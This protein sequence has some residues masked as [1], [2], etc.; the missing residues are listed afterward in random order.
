MESLAIMHYCSSY[1]IAIL[2]LVLAAISP[3]ARDGRGTVSGGR[4]IRG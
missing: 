4:G 1:A 3:F 2:R